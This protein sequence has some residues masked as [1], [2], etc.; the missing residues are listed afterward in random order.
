MKPATRPTG[1]APCAGPGF[2]ARLL[3]LAIGGML[4]AAAGW[5]AAQA[6]PVRPVRIIVPFSTGTAAD[7]VARQLATRLAESWGQ[8]VTVENLQGAGGNVGAVAAAKANPDGHTL[9][10]LGINHVINPSLYPNTGYD[11]PRDFRPG[12]LQAG[13]SSSS[14]IR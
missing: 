10:M 4:L 12:A 13:R 1:P 3:R 2:A 8:G 5:A 14:R 9:L 11:I 7:I 6:Y